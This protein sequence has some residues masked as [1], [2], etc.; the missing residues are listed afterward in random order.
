MKPE[1]PGDRRGAAFAVSVNLR[2]HTARP[3]TSFAWREHGARL[4]ASQ[5]WSHIAIFFPCDWVEERK[6]HALL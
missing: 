6:C 5:C 3:R 2:D 4:G 1:S